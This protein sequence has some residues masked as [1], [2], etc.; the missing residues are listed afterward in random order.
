LFGFGSGVSSCAAFF[1]DPSQQSALVRR[2]PTAPACES[3]RFIAEY[4][5]KCLYASPRGIRACLPLQLPRRPHCPIF[6]FFWT[7]RIP[8]CRH[9][10]IPVRIATRGTWPRCVS[11]PLLLRLA[12]NPFSSILN[13]ASTQLLTTQV[14]E[15]HRTPCASVS[16]GCRPRPFSLFRRQLPLFL[17]SAVTLSPNSDSGSAPAHIY[18]TQYRCPHTDLRTQSTTCR[19]APPSSRSLPSP[20]FPSFSLSLSCFAFPPPLPAFYLHSHATRDMQPASAHSIPS[21]ASRGHVLRFGGKR[22]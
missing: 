16:A 17:P 9:P 3:H 18:P 2:I 11:P 7:D 13:L 5:L 21:C 22:G 10:S 1:P 14:V 6:S 20:P 12:G 19:Y 8:R 4:L 15:G